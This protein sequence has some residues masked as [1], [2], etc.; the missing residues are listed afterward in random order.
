ME[1]IPEGMTVSKHRYKEILHCLRNSVRRKHPE[2]C[3]RKNWL[4]LRDNAPA[5]HFVLVQEELEKQQITVLPHPPCSPE[6][7]P[8]D[9]FFFPRLKEK[10]RECLFQSTEIITATRETIQDLPVDIFQHC[11]QQLY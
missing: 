4:L 10:L 6:L 5:H 11:F 1:F 2:L 9:F 7:A 3:R 8:F